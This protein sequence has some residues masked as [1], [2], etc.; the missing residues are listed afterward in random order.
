M[1]SL[2]SFSSIFPGDQLT[3]FAPMCGRPCS[4][5]SVGVQQQSVGKVDR[6]IRWQY[7]TTILRLRI[8][9]RL[10]RYRNCK[11]DNGCRT[12]SR[13]ADGISRYAVPPSAGGPLLPLDLLV[14]RKPP[15]RWRLEC[16]AAEMLHKIVTSNTRYICC[17]AVAF[18]QSDG[19]TL[20]HPSSVAVIPH[21]LQ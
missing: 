11:F 21:R 2:V 15:S 13:H 9:A 12:I 18:S 8:G 20:V 4:C 19:S 16:E 6:W 7:T 17:E 1:F 3:P 5:P 14:S 10:T